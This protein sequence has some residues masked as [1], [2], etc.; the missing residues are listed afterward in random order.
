MSAAS[1]IREIREY[2]NMT[3]AEFA[4]E[5]GV[6][7][8]MVGMLENGRRLPGVKTLPGILSLATREQNEA[9]LVAARRGAEGY[10]KHKGA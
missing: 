7:E 10:Y 3:R 6:T 2:R 4:S 1:I 9:L 8:R 5:L